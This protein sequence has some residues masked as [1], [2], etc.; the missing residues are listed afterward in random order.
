MSRVWVV[1]PTY[2]EGDT[3]RGLVAATAAQLDRLERSWRLLVV[4]DNSPDGTGAI[5][6]AL[7]R[8]HAEVEVLHRPGKEGLGRAYQAGF[9]RALA[10]GADVVVQ[11]DADFSHDPAHLPALLEALEQADL[12]LGSRYAPGGRI[13]DWGPLRRLL[14]RGGSAYARR[15]LG[16]GIRDLP[17]GYKVWRREALER[18]EVASVRSEG[19]AFQIELTHR[20]CHAGLRVREIPIV[21]RDRRLGASKMT[22]RIALEAAWLVPR[23]RRRA[24]VTGRAR[25]DALRGDP[26]T[27]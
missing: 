19:Y 1:V 26:T 6:D 24:P 11:M 3:L 25:R 22:G 15:V 8:E 10:A 21:F 4:D 13:E 17:G 5:A 18:V 14:S 23:M 7:A 27:P 2:N 9:A 12:A 16:L 20:A